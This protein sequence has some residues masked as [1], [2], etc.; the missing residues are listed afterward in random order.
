[1]LMCQSRSWPRPSSERDP[2]WRDRREY[3]CLQLPSRLETLRSLPPAVSL[4]PSLP[5][6][7]CF[8]HFPVLGPPC[9]FSF[10]YR[11][12]SAQKQGDKNEAPIKGTQKCTIRGI[13]ERNEG[14]RS[15]DLC[16]FREPITAILHH[17]L[18]VVGYYALP[19]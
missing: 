6:T 1:M 17:F 8:S 14:V 16:L 12:T 5:L 4:S 15:D 9:F 2:K 19:P 10:H 11:N 13:I 18:P 7:F 3:Q